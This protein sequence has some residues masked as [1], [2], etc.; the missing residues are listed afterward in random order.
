MATHALLE[1]AL[2]RAEDEAGASLR[3]TA[4]LVRELRR[5]QVGAREGQARELRR[6]VAAARQQWEVLG[7]RLEGLE[8][9]YDVDETEHLASGAFVAEV[10]A[11]AQRTGV[12]ISP[13]PDAPDRLLSYPSVVR[14]LPG[15]AAV[16]IDKRRERRLRPS[17]LVARLGR[18]QQRPP[19]FRAEAFVEALAVGY[20]LV[21]ARE[22]RDPGAVVR[23]D[24]VW[25]VLTV[26][27]GARTDYGRP[28]FARDLYLLDQ[29]AVVGTRDGRR[30]RFAASTGT[31]GAGVLTTVAR[32]GQQQLYWGVSFVAPPPRGTD[33]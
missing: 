23:L 5:A 19:R 7:E 1:D 16:E 3:A 29:S 2:A 10:L 15:E 13:D 6:G 17:L 4:A 22:G 25:S 27:P 20:E 11:E 21:T 33:S 24:A 14:V 8:S 26:L 12:V 28:E 31:R 32:G 18:N 30:F 9:A